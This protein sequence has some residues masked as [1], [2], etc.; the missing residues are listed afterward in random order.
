MQIGSAMREA[1]KNRGLTQ[2]ELAEMAGMAV[3]SIRLYESGKRIPSIDQRIKIADKLDCSPFDF[4]TEGEAEAFSE[5]FLLG[6]WSREEEFHDELE[7]AIV[8]LEA[9]KD[10]P[11]YANMITAYKKLN[12]EGKIEAAKR[13]EE[14]ATHPKYMLTTSEEPLSDVDTTTDTP[15]TEKPPEGQNN[16]ADGK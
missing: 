2:V 16:P 12:A 14:L 4:M 6:Y 3:N 15:A 10:D 8:E 13:V 11:L 7:F 5:H 9:R 1:R